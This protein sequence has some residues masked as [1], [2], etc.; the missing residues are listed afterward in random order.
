MVLVEV[1]SLAGLQLVLASQGDTGRPG[2]PPTRP[3]RAPPS[4]GGILPPWATR[5]WP[6]AA[7]AA[8]DAATAQDACEAWPDMSVVPQY[9]AMWRVLSAWAAL[10]DGRSGRGPP[11][12]R[13]G[14]HGTT[15]YFLSAALLARAQVRSRKGRRNKANATPTTRSRVPP[16]SG[17]TC[18][19]PT[20]SNASPV[21]RATA[22]SHREAARLF[23]AAHAIRE[24][25]GASPVSRSGARAAKLPSRRCET[26][27]A[28]TTL[29]QR[30]LRAPPY[31]SR[32]RSLM[33]SAVAVNA[34][35]RQPA[36]ARSR[37]P[38]VTW[39]GWSVRDWAIRTSPPG[40]SSRRG[41]CNPIS[42]TSTP[43]ST[44]PRG[45]NW[46]TR[47]LATRR[48]PAAVVDELPPTC[49]KRSQICRIG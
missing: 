38:S 16:K 41:R 27:W 40:F 10:R 31:R 19:F 37:P 29:N 36:G 44:S 3:S 34:N 30:G 18:P 7:L 49:D 32:R 24:R 14:G 12:G 8:G 28:R 33:R 20:S 2:P 15:G 9:A 45:C 11:L 47:R 5:H 17:L 35:A 6:A 39:C 13:R 42:R 4:V 26:H 46:L 25:R 48:G 22:G 43:N 1:G 23:G 21:W